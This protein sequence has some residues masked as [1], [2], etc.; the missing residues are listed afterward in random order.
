MLAERLPTILPDLDDADAL[1]ATAIRSVVAD[2]Q[3]LLR[4]PPFH[5]PHHTATVAALVGGGPRR[6]ALPGCRHPGPR[7]GGLGTLRR[8]SALSP[9]Y[10]GRPCRRTFGFKA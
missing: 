9:L 6:S 4:R 7:R 8:V 1:T 10:A 3:G 2:V 5:A